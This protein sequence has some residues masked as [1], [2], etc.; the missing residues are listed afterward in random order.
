MF[1]VKHR[2]SA[3]PFFDVSRLKIGRKWKKVGRKWKKGWLPQMNLQV[4]E[5]VVVFMHQSCPHCKNWIQLLNIM[6]LKEEM[7]SVTGI[8]SLKNEESMTSPTMRS[9]PRHL[10]G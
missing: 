9:L 5:H 8:L 1:H 2:C 4:G 6:S 10:S 7:P 3:I